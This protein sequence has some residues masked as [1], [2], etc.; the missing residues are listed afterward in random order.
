MDF[1]V[2]MPESKR[3][4]PGGRTEAVLSYNELTQ[5]RS[6]NRHVQQFASPGAVPGTVLEI[7]VFNNSV[8]TGLT[9]GDFETIMSR[10]LEPKRQGELR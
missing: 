2:A 4:Q 10:C 1:V 7:C 5:C 8:S 9:S 3:P 6:G